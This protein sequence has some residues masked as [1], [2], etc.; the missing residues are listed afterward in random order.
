MSEYKK[1]VEIMIEE[2]KE[3]FENFLDIHNEYAM[4][5][6]AWQKLFNQYGSEVVEIVRDYERKL[7]AHMSKGKFGKFSANL[8]EKYW[9]EV[10]KVFPKIDFVGVIQS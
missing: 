4:N 10:R 6:P 8:S 3:L 5:P 1:M 2:H 7:C 9:D